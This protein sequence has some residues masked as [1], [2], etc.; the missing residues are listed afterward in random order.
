[1]NRRQFRR[2][3]CIVP[4]PE[5][6]RENRNVPPRPRPPAR[7]L[8]PSPLSRRLNSPPQPPP[9]R[10]RP[11]EPQNLFSPPLDR[12]GVVYTL[13]GGQPP[14]RVHSQVVKSRIS[15]SP[16]SN[17]P[18]LHSPPRTN[19]ISPHNLTH[20]KRPRQEVLEHQAAPYPFPETFQAAAN[21]LQP[22]R[23]AVPRH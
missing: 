4:R 16:R 7:Q 6:P 3:G 5:H 15:P 10:P 20:P 23:L 13:C 21:N 11:I 2:R 18:P 12:F 17:L 9:P 22:P 8:P 1:M 19:R 14:P